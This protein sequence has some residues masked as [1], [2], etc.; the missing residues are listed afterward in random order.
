MIRL[1][2]WA[3]AAY[4]A[5][6][7]KRWTGPTAFTLSAMNDILKSVFVDELLEAQLDSNRALFDLINAKH[8]GVVTLRAPK[9]AALL[10]G[11][12]G[13]KY[14]RRQRRKRAQRQRRFRAAMRAITLAPPRR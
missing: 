6:T 8:S 12:W 9:R 10:P 14:G 5:L 13:E 4:V 3:A 11:G 1:I 2:G 7:R